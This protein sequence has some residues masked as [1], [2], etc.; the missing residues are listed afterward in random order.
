MY[1]L[2]S[3]LP[4]PDFPTVTLHSFVLFSIHATCPAHLILSHLLAS[5]IQGYYRVI[6]SVL[7]PKK[8]EY[9][10]DYSLDFEYIFVIYLHINIFYIL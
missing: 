4:P 10:K 5:I 1:S 7:D 8:C 9:L 3:G 6:P 2:P